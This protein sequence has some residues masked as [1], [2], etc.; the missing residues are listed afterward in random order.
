[1]LLEF[2]S[3][4]H[5]GR[6]DLYPY[7]EAARLVVEYKRRFY[8]KRDAPKVKSVSPEELELFKL[9]G[10]EIRIVEVK[11]FNKLKPKVG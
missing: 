3:K 1:M 2:E 9:L 8:S 7:N 11:D 6:V 4:Q 10:H 5:F